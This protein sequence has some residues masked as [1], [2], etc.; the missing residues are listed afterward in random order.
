MIE[1]SFCLKKKISGQGNERVNIFEAS[2]TE[3]GKGGRGEREVSSKLVRKISQPDLI[4]TLSP[5]AQPAQPISSELWIYWKCVG[6]WLCV[7][8]LTAYQTNTTHKNLG[9]K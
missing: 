9:K 6:V 8:K 1:A 3:A 7:D 2:Q 5:R 4:W